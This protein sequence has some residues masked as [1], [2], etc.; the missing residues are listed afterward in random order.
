M[1]KPIT[2][3]RDANNATAQN[4][5]VARAPQRC[6]NCKGPR[7]ADNSSYPARPFVRRG[8]FTHLYRL[9]LRRIRQAGQQAWLLLNPNTTTPP[10]TLNTSQ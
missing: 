10:N 6:A 2:T 5:L 1:L 7:A 8:I 9:E 4:T 3:N